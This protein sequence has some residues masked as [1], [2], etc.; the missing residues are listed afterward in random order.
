MQKLVSF[1]PEKAWHTPDDDRTEASNLYIIYTLVLWAWSPHMYWPF[2]L[3]ETC[4][5]QSR[6]QVK[7][8]I[9]FPCV[10]CPKI[11]FCQS[12]AKAPKVQM[13]VR[14]TLLNYYCVL[15][16]FYHCPQLTHDYYKLLW[17]STH[18]CTVRGAIIRSQSGVHGLPWNWSYCCHG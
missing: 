10:F 9:R 4:K 11:C 12:F 13:L 3:L 7:P 6:A 8:C 17:F 2:S 14:N 18:S 1:Y 15:E 16:G 5:L